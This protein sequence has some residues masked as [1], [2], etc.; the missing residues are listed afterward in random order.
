MI[1]F[2]VKIP[3]FTLPEIS[4]SQLKLVH[5]IF[6]LLSKITIVYQNANLHFKLINFLKQERDRKRE[7]YHAVSD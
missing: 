2:C 6:G 1:H 7:I 4:I 3:K 5:P